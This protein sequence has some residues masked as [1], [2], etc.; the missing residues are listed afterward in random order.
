MK[1]NET[2]A[3]LRIEISIERENEVDGEESAVKG[4]ELKV[5]RIKL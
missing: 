2:N 1:R 5:F 3:V 4:T